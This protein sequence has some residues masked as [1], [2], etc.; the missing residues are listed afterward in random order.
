[1]SSRVPYAMAKDKLFFSK[2]SEVNS[3]TKSPVYSILVQAC[4]AII[5]ALSGTFD[6]LTDY[7]VFSAWLFYSLAGVSLFI[8]RKKIPQQ[9]R[10]YKA[11]GY[12]VIPGLFVL[13]SVL[14]LINT[15]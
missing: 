14:L 7:V 1:T 3:K 6:Q 9:H 10:S 15:I 5:L 4:I 2:L 12:P 13:C 8:F 11:W